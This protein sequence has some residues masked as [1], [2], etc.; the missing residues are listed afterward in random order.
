MFSGSSTA[1]SRSQTFTWT[2]PLR[3]CRDVELIENCTRAVVVFP[4][5]TGYV[6]E[7]VTTSA[8]LPISERKRHSWPLGRGVK[9]EEVF[10]L[11]SATNGDVNFELTFAVWTHSFPHCWLYHWYANRICSVVTESREASTAPS[12]N[13]LRRIHFSAFMRPTTTLGKKLSGA[14]GFSHSLY[15]ALNHAVW[16]SSVSCSVK[17]PCMWSLCWLVAGRRKVLLL[18]SRHV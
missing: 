8:R 1:T 5:I 16:R 14:L 15:D 12:Y 2:S 10:V 4:V 11:S 7:S 17:P 6:D 9:G 3:L 13:S 18:F